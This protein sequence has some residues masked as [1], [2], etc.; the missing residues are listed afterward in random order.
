MSEDIFGYLTL[1]GAHCWRLVGSDQLLLLL[2][3]FSCVLPCVT[4]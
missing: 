3:R 2:S 1:E 4:P